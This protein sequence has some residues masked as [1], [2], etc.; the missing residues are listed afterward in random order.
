[1]E[2]AIKKI[3]FYS[4]QSS[5]RLRYVLQF[6]TE[7]IWENEIVLTQDLETYKNYKGLKINYS[8]TRQGTKELLIYPS[9]LLFEN[10]I[11]K[12]NI[13]LIKWKEHLAFFKSPQN[14]VPFDIF[15]AIFYLLSRYEEYIF[16]GTDK[17]GRFDVSQ[18]V[19][20]HH[21]HLPI[22]NIWLLHLGYQLQGSCYTNGVKSKPYTYQ[23]SYDIDISHAFLGRNFTRI[24]GGMWNDIKSQKFNTLSQRIR[25]MRNKEKDPYDTFDFIDYM[26]EKNNMQAIYFFLLGN[27]KGFDKNI[28]PHSEILK[29]L[30]QKTAKKNTLGIHPSFQSNKDKEILQGEINLLKTYLN[31]DIKHSRQHYIYLKLPSTYHNLIALGIEHD[32]SMGYGTHNGF[33]AGTG[34][35]FYWF[36]LEKN[37]QSK[38]KVHPFCFMDSTSKYILEQDYKNT[39]KEIKKLI[40][41]CKSYHTCFTSIWH[42]FTFALNDDGEVYRSIYELQLY[43]LG[44]RYL[45][46]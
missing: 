12:Q 46:M 28:N 19:L 22:I 40:A 4:E 24:L 1:M 18:S 6:I 36:D 15:A 3:I 17:F 34:N 21:L 45:Y 25:V 42:N 10:N 35:S 27:Q 39:L 8:H 14:I 41:L 37:E 32:Y 9:T 31:Q 5:P 7:E 16:D 33:R 23:L 26:H 11:K 43:E 30:I 2:T 13:E 38:L 20:K 29:E 44:P